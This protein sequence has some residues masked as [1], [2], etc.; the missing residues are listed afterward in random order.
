MGPLSVIAAVAVIGTGALVTTFTAQTLPITAE[1]AGKNAVATAHPP[2]AMKMGALSSGK[3]FS[4]A[5][6]AYRGGAFSNELAFSMTSVVVQHPKGT[7]V[8]DAGWSKN[9]DAHFL[10]TPWMMQKTSKYE[11]EPTVP[12]Q[13]EAAGVPL[14]T[15]TAIVLTHSHWDHV[16]GLEDMPGVPVWVSPKELEFANGDHHMTVLARMIGTKDYKA[17]P[18]ASGPYLGF[19]SS[20]DV[21]AD[22]SVVIVP[23]L[24]HTPGSIIAFINTPDNK[25]YALVGDL[26]W[27]SEGIDFP[28]EKPWFVRKMVEYDEA[29]VR[30]LLVKMHNLKTQ[31]PD[32]V[33]VPAHDRR[34]FEKLPKLTPLAK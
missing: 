22:G 7:L 21:F 32:L 4:A 15:L 8:F 20:H 23:A 29:A 18:F 9:V 33:V 14:K 27:Q 19:D 28:A 10:T 26:A 3:M 34:V 1:G 12:Q 30:S 6:F 25:H 11:K 13:L 5:A 16:S 31:I 2:A 17:M 24:G